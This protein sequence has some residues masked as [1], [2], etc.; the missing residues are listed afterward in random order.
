MHAPVVASQLLHTMLRVVD[1]D[2]SKRFYCDV[3]GMR[4]LRE[5]EYPDGRFTLCFL[6]YGDESSHTVIE[7][8]FN[9]DKTDPTSYEQGTAFGHLAVGTPDV[10]AL[11]E[12]VRS[13]GFKVTREA[14]AMKFKAQPVP[15]AAPNETASEGPPPRSSVIA[16]IEDP[17]GYKVEL[18]ERTSES[19]EVG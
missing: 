13:A 7:L 1:L 11:C 6:G 4:V 8:T 19:P 12:K 10:A 16:F 9:W 15:G 18:I 14:G 2:A 3:L 5:R 17:S